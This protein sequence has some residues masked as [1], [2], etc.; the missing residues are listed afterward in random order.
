MSPQERASGAPLRRLGEQ[1]S[2]GNYLRGVWRRREFVWTIAAGNL[3]AQHLDTTLGNLWH[4]V[5]PLLLLGV[6]YLV[7]GVIIDRASEDVPNFI[8]FLAVGIFLFSYC[9]RSISGGAS[10]IV[11]NVGL[12]R[13]LQF[14]RAILPAAAVLQQLLAFGSGASVMLI[15]LLVTGE[16][17]DFGWFV[18]VPLVAVATMFSVGGALVTARLTDQVRDIQNVLPYVFRLL[19]YMSGILYSVDRLI[20]DPRLK[21]VFL[22][23]PFYDIVGIGRH[24]LMSTYDEPDVGLMVIALIAITGVTLAGGIVF[25]RKGEGTYGRG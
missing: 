3:R 23:N 13:S 16:R 20:T 22:L 4:I 8:G 6:Y 12:I 2:L 17:P 19:F 1:E 18:L 15:M 14:P 5:N 10:S 25:F 21:M 24:F 9:Q 11:G 7:F